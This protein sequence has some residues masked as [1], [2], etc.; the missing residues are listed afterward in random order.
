MQISIR[1]LRYY[2]EMEL[3]CPALTD[4]ATGYRYYGVDQLSV[5]QQIIF[6]RDVGFNVNEIRE[7]ISS[8]KEHDTYCD[9][10]NKKS[11]EISISIAE[12]QKKIEK[13]NECMVSIN[14]N[15]ENQN[16]NFVIKKIPKY[17]VLSL[18][19]ILPDYFS[20]GMLWA[21]LEEY[22][23][24]SKIKVLKTENDF[25]IYHDNEYKE[26]HV[27]IEVCA[28]LEAEEKVDIKITGLSVRETDEVKNMACAMVYGK[29][30]NIKTAYNSFAFW[31][32]NNIS[33]RMT[34]RNRQICHKGPWN[35]KDPD[36]YLTEIQIP[37]EIIA[38]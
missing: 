2:D 9:M 6:L 4:G 27:D 37:V 24:N 21:E 31:L 20:E 8:D 28:V 29:Y 23:K 18:R 25:A 14:N 17:K 32:G 26:S 5:L 16:Y 30:E 1:M 7:A 11:I 33:Y 3:F 35:E 12:Y 10:L 19:R 15:A 13:I 36:K 38:H 22:V 34:G